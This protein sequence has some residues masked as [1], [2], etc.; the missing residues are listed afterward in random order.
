MI[1]II[2]KVITIWW[3]ELKTINLNSGMTRIQITNSVYIIVNT[4]TEY[5]ILLSEF[6][7]FGRHNCLYVTGSEWKNI[8]I[9]S[10]I[11][12]DILLPYSKFD[13]VHCF[14]GIAPYVSSISVL[15]LGI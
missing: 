8:L 4:Q 11:D 1:K 2:I 6:R 12:S 15:F 14:G 5:V 3:S 7:I 13:P 10:I 9:F